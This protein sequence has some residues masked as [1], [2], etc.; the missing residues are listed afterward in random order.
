MEVSWQDVSIYH[1]KI[2]KTK[3]LTKKGPLKFLK[4]I[5]ANFRHGFGLSLGKIWLW[6]LNQTIRFYFGAGR[7]RERGSIGG[8]GGGEEG[9]VGICWLFNIHGL[10][11]ITWVMTAYTSPTTAGK[12]W[13]LWE[14][15]WALTAY[16]GHP[17]AVKL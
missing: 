12:L 5:L 9:V 10:F 11:Y 2:L 3:N 1:V 7:G 14:L 15:T 6:N 4:I 17:N 16:I 13:Q 8:W